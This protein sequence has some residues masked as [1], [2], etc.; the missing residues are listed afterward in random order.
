MRRLLPFV[1]WLG[2]FAAASSAQDITRLEKIG[3]IT[4]FTKTERGVTF[5]CRDHSQVQ[6]LVLAPDLIR[7]RAA[8]AKSIPVKDHSWA[9]AKDDWAETSWQLRETT[10]SV[11]VSTD[12]VEVVVHRSP[13]LIDFRDARTHV[14]L[15]ADEQPMAYDAKGAMAQ[16]MFDPQ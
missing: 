2:C 13:L 14:L 4:G 16:G 5:D 12:E 7:V 8:F 6:L 11:I 10:D 1:L 3:P 9:I 15:N